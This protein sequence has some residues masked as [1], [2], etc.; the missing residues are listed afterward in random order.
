VP[1]VRIDTKPSTG[2][3]WTAVCTDTTA[4]YS[5]TA[6]T[7][8]TVSGNLDI[9]AVLADGSGGTATSATV[10]VA[11]DNQPFRALDVQAV[12][13]AGAGKLATGDQLVLTY[14]ELVSTASIKPGWNGSSTTI[15][16]NLGSVTF[17]QNYLSASSSV[18][19][20]GSTMVASTQTVGGRQV[21]VVTVTLGTPSAP[22]SLS[23]ANTNGAMVW[24]PSAQ[25][26]T[27]DGQACSTT[28]VTETGT[29]DRDF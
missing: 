2:S 10:T 29:A 22:S 4:P 18:T 3:T 13:T 24:T 12:N 26:R 23:T 19:F 8:G 15:A 7:T 9:R 27:P 14:S 6:D 25:V 17:A 5:C 20:S 16:P 28:P 21:T 1:S 11:V